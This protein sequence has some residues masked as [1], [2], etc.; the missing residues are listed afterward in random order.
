MPPPGGRWG[1][2]VDGLHRAGVDIHVL[3]RR[4]LS[5]ADD[6][7][8]VMAPYENAENEAAKGTNQESSSSELKSV[9]HRQEKLYPEMAETSVVVDPCAENQICNSRKAQTSS[10]TT[11]LHSVGVHAYR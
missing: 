6:V 4:D 9:M 10:S 7:E 11:S 8:R 3:M 1:E 5:I 2:G